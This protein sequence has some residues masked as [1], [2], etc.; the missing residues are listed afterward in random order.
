MKIL[1]DEQLPVKLKYRFQPEFEIST[2]RDEHWLG[3]KNGA[4]LSLAYNSGFTVF[5]TN[6][7][8][9]VYQQKLIQF[10]ILFININQPSNRYNDILSVIFKI[11]EWLLKNKNEPDLTVRKNY[12]LFPDDF[13]D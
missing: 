13:N 5:I 1:L 4:L 3:T 12:L 6:D 8:S 9:L 11:K 2:V 10:E 7:Q